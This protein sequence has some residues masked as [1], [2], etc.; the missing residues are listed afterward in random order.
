VAAVAKQTREAMLD[1]LG[2]EHIRMAWASGLSPRSIVFRHALKNASPRMLTVLGV[3]AVGMLGGTI[4]VE[5]VFALPG[6]GSLAV[7][8]SVQ[9]DLP[10]VQGVAVYFTIIVVI[11]NLLIDAA[12]MWLNPKVK[13]Q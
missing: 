2:S 12:Y 1:A 5:S 6:L 7:T 4:L 3:Q 10:L 8:A 13:T 9:H 11:V